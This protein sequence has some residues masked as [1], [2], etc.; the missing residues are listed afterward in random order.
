MSD[1]PRQQRPPLGF[2]QR[3]A[4]PSTPPREFVP[5][6]HR[7]QAPLETEAENELPTTAEPEPDDEL[8]KAL[9][10]VVKST[11]RRSEPPTTREA[12]LERTGSTLDLV[13]AHVLEQ[14]NSLRSELDAM[15]KL[16]LDDTSRLKAELQ[17]HVSMADRAS[18]QTDRMKELM[19][20]LRAERARHVNARTLP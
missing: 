17:S 4:Q 10:Q 13:T 20:D 19:N 5:P 11:E 14:I 18:Q 9:A 15:E 1:Q 7:E 8:K 16:I 2:P 3:P 6:K 12:V